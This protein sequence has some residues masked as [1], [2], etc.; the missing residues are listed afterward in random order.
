MFSAGITVPYQLSGTD[1]V[2]GGTTQNQSVT[3]LGDIDIYGKGTYVL[4]DDMNLHFGLGLHWG[5]NKRTYN[6][7]KYD[8]GDNRLDLVPYVGYVY[9]LGGFTLGAKL[10]FELGLVKA[11]WQNN[12]DTPPDSST[13]SGGDTTKATLF[14]E[15][16]FSGGLAGLAVSYRA[17]SQHKETFSNSGGSFNDEDGTNW[18]DIDLYATFDVADGITII[19]AVGY[20]ILEDS[21]YLSNAV[22]NGNDIRASVAGRFTF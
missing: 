10:S 14:G 13:V 9:N 4:A 17:I 20:S 5:L 18:I 12:T 6:A 2:D 19:P 16:P 22:S 3:G 21:Y 15:L 8:A 11:K 1:K 7:T